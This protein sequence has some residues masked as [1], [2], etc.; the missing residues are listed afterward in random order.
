[1]LTSFATKWLVENILSQL[2]QTTA[3]GDYVIL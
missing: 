3:Y 2:L 1:M